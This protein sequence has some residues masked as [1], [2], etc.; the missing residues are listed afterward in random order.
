MNRIPKMT[1]AGAAIATVIL[2]LLASVLVT[3]APAAADELRVRK[4]VT[5]LTPHERKQFVDAVHLLK[6]T[7]SPWAPGISWYDHFVRWHLYLNYCDRTDPAGR[8]QMFGHGGPMFLPWHREYLGVVEDAL[9]E[10]SGTGVTIPYWDWTDRE[11]VERVFAPDFMGGD[12]DPNDGWFVKTG[13]FRKGVWRLNVQPEGVRAKTSESDWL[14]RSMG[15][16]SMLP[17]KEDVAEVLSRPRYDAAPYDDTSDPAVSFRNALEGFPRNSPDGLRTLNGCDPD[18][19]NGTIPN[20]LRSGGGMHNVVHPFVGG[21]TDPTG[22]LSAGTMSNIQTSPNDPSFFL[23]HANIDRLWAKWQATNGRDTYEPS[24]GYEHNDVDSV[25]RPFEEAGKTVTPR[26]VADIT[27]LGYAYL[28]PNGEIL[29]GS[30]TAEASAAPAG[31]QFNC[32]LR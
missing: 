4:S 17:T 29:R 13:P 10:V 6:R 15:P 18:G 22:Q 19:H 9:Q 3:A 20:P 32:Q 5:D 23:H 30:T 31:M 28:E 14:T 2:A 24:S 26:D 16:T 25:I 27:A 21:V 7:P 12:G 1:T 8:N 11:S